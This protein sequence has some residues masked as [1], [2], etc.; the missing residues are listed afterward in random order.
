[1]S[2]YWNRKNQTATYWQTSLGGGCTQQCQLFLDLILKEKELDYH[3]L[4][5]FTWKMWCWRV[6]VVSWFKSIHRQTFP[7]T[8]G[9]RIRPP[10]IDSWH[11]K[12]VMLVRFSCFFICF[13]SQAKAS[14]SWRERIKPPHICLKDEPL[15]SSNCFFIFFYSQANVSAYWKR[16]IQTITHY[17]TPLEEL[18]ARNKNTFFVLQTNMNEDELLEILVSYDSWDW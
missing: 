3:I 15:N 5:D 6:S 10:H 14:A 18:N 2:A 1:M 12:D 17:Q 7:H 9:D 8:E 16:I 13:C 4:T 11:L